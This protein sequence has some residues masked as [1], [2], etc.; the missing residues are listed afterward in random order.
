MHV[1]VQ[2]PNVDMDKSA[3]DIAKMIVKTLVTK[4]HCVSV[5]FTELIDLRSDQRNDGICLHMLVVSQ[6]EG[7]ALVL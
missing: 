2:I 5:T 4:N 6:S 3:E 7:K 1:F